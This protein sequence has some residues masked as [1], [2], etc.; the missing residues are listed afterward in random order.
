MILDYFIPE[1]CIFCGSFRYYSNLLINASLRIANGFT[2]SPTS[3]QSLWDGAGQANHELIHK[4][5]INHMTLEELKIIKPN[6]ELIKKGKKRIEGLIKDAADK[7]DSGEAFKPEM[8]Q[9]KIDELWPEEIALFEEVQEILE[10]KEDINP[11]GREE[12]EVKLENLRSELSNAQRPDKKSLAPLIAE[13][14]MSID[15]MM[16]KSE[17]EKREV[18]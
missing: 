17:A 13:G 7:K 8:E 3:N 15:A 1:I 14:I 6:K 10:N 16:L 11:E 4:I 5:K 12:L 2:N 9:I 18:A